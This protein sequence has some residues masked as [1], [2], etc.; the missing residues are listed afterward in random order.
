MKVKKFICRN[1]GAP[2]VTPYTLP[3]IVCD[4][5]NCFTDI[6]FAIGMDVW[7]KNPKRTNRY[8]KEKLKFESQLADL[9][10]QKNKEGYYKMQISYWDFYYKTFPEYLPPSLYKPEDYS[11]F[12]NICA[13]SMSDYVFNNPLK[14]LEDNYTRLQE[15]VVYKSVKDKTVAE[16][17]SFFKFFESYLAY[18]KASF[19]DFYDA[20]ENAIMHEL[21]PEE[22]Q[23]K[24]KLSMFAQAWI[25]YLTEEDSRKLLDRLNF[26]NE[27]VEINAPTLTSTQCPNC[28]VELKIIPESFK[29]YCENCCTTQILKTSYNCV[30][31]G[32]LNPTPDNVAKPI[33]CISCATVNNLV[34]A[35]F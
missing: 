13:K 20:P 18:F 34:L 14:H 31:C 23:Y 5:C 28:T 25:P 30:S 2:K 7:N 10:K 32:A 19:S 24:M 26:T 33:P 6:D 8:N 11:L 17:A 12:I 1:C 29:V 35:H 4:Y 3:Y 16:S 9:I 27:Y 21:L 15:Q 22:L